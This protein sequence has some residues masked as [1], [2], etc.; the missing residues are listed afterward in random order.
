[1]KGGM[2]GRTMYLLLLLILVALIVALY[3]LVGKNVITKLFLG[4]LK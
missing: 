1:M 2:S 3:Y 4:G